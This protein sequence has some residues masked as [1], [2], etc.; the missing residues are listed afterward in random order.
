MSTTAARSIDLQ[1]CYRLPWSLSD[2][3]ISWLEVT[4]SC[5]L[6]CKGCYRPKEAGHKSLEQIAEELTVFKRERK[7]DCMSIAGGDPLVHPQIL[8]I[9]KMVRHGGW[10]PIIN[11]N[12]L[13]LT[14]ERLKQLKAAGAFGFTLHIDTSQK[15][16]DSEA[17]QESDHNPLRQRF[18]EMLAHEGGLSCS[19]NQTV[20]QDTL[21]DIP[22]VLAWAKKFPEI[23][24]T[25]VFILYREPKLFPGFE[26]FARGKKVPLGSTYE[27]PLDWG[28]AK[29]LKA[30]DVIERIREVEPDYSPNSYLNGTEDANSAKW[31]L[32]SRFAVGAHTLGYA[33]GKFMEIAQEYHHLTKKRWLSYASPKE[34]QSGRMASLLLAPVD[35]KM[36]SILGRYI[37]H[38]A[39][40]PVRFL[41]K[42]NIQTITIIQPI[43]V[44]P[45]GRMN[46]CDGCPDMTVYN[47][48]MYWSCRLEEVKTYG[49]F[50][51]AAPVQNPVV[52]LPDQRSHDSVSA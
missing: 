17:T 13:A 12:G 46:M 22:S 27:Q 24:N 39:L 36:R 15:R 14:P 42:V 1:Q 32:A 52:V 51:N 20:T 35:R 50:V 8:D 7:S 29:P 19:F 44:L 4:S 40:N 49:C 38:A 48:K 11:T 16:K 34:L 28:G 30:D 26:Y 45:D 6:A 37:K 25:I 47:G 18:A 3:G 41:K 9:V 23:V 21:K 5:N 10:K 31:L 43:D 2:N 33:S